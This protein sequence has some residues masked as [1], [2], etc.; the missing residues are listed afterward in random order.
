VNN[1]RSV[2]PP[3]KNTLRSDLTAA[4][5][6]RRRRRR[7]TLKTRHGKKWSDSER[8]AV[9]DQLNAGKSLSSIADQLGRTTKAIEC[10]LIDL[11]RLEDTAGSTIPQQPPA[12]PIYL[13]P[14]LRQT[15]STF[16]EAHRRTFG[17]QYWAGR[18]L[19]LGRGS[20]EM[21][22]EFTKLTVFLR[23]LPDERW[24]DYMVYAMEVDKHWKTGV[25]PVSLASD[26]H[27]A[28]FKSSPREAANVAASAPV[29]ADGWLSGAD[30]D[31][32]SS[33]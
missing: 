11:G 24:G 3:Q 1:Y 9:L 20:Q 16:C 14:I 13:T 4:G 26:K 23:Q 30:D 28:A 8:Q 17:T 32:C 25:R 22:A 19:L 27:L 21:V 18:N 10:Q 2:Q 31:F 29:S 12:P 6:Y 15:I 5:A 7:I 33:E